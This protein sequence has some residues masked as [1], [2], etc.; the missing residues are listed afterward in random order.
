MFMWVLATAVVQGYICHLMLVRKQRVKF[1]KR[2]GAWEMRRSQRRDIDL[3][4]E[5]NRTTKLSLAEYEAHCKTHRPRPLT[6][7]QF[8]T[9]LAESLANY[10]TAS[11]AMLTNRDPR[12]RRNRG[13]PTSQPYFPNRHVSKRPCLRKYYVGPDKAKAQMIQ[14]VRANIPNLRLF[15]GKGRKFSLTSEKGMTRFQGGDVIPGIHR[16][17]TLKGGRSRCQVCRATGKVGAY[18]PHKTR[19]PPRAKITCA[20]PL[21]GG[22]SLCSV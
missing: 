5:A 18:G 12:T 8:R 9:T 16:L 19:E 11:N 10:N 7:I 1:D 4:Q 15:A 3:S 6:H 13:R 2:W 17:K 22:I 14:P 20:N 21:C